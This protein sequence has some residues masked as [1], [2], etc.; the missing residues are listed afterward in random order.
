MKKKRPKEQKRLPGEDRQTGLGGG[1]GG[2]S[3]TARRRAGAPG[4]G[5]LQ[6]WVLLCR[7]QPL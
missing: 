2:G 7:A 3:C 4:P 6:D 5:L 1:P